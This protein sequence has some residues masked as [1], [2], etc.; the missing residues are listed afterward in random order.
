MQSYSYATTGWPP[1]ENIF[2]LLTWDKSAPDSFKK[3]LVPEMRQGKSKR[4]MENPIVIELM[5][6]NPHTSGFRIQ[7]LLAIL[8]DDSVLETTLC[9]IR[10]CSPT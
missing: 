1:I 9:G 4:V 8:E 5:K 6:Y 2:R 3:W 10:S 7:E